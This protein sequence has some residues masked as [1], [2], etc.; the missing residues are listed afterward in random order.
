MNIFHKPDPA[1]RL[2]MM[3]VILD[4]WG[5]RKPVEG[6]AVTSARTPVMDRLKRQYPYTTLHAHGSYVGLPE[7]QVGNSEAGHMNIGAGRLVEQDSVKISR[8]I[9]D[10]TFFKNSA[11]L[12]ALRHISRMGSKLHLIGMLSNGQGPH[13]DPRHL[14]ALLDLAARHNVKQVYLHLFTDGRDSPK[15]ASLQLMEDLVKRYPKGYAVATVIGRFYAMD[16]KKKWERTAKSF[17]A[18]TKGEGRTA[19]TPQDAITEAYNRGESDEFIPPYVITGEQAKKSRIEDGDSVIFFNLRSDRSRQLA[20]AFVQNEFT[21]MNPGSFQ[22][23]DKPQHLYFVAMTDFGP[24]LDDILTAYPSVDLKGVLPVQLGDLKQLYIAETEKYAHVTYFFNGGYSG[25][26]AGEEQIMVPSPD[27]KSY[28]QTPAM[29]SEELVSVI[30]ESVQAEGGPRYDFTVLNFAAPD[31]VGHTGNLEAAIACCEQVDGYLG[32]LVRVYSEAGG[33]LVVT[34]DHG[35]IEKMINNR[36]G[37]LYTE[38]TTNPVPFILVG[39][40]MEREHIRLS[41]GG[42]LGNI[43]PTILDLL[44][45]ERPPEMTSDSLLE[46]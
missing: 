41:E 29:S 28:D 1:G 21:K 45:R 14:Y 32:E 10:G 34:A 42:S 8:S 17:A 6:N 33:T 31:M 12:G 2:P 27:V 35:N 15:Y 40:G 11:F 13:S 36:T 43:A 18:L 44:G 9:D 22:R 39:P 16:R 3:L 46:K 24:D 20:K 37:E 30:R 19:K 23:G 5:I 38:H 25:T 7:G 26:V 4:G